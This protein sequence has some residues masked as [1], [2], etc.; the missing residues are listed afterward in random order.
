MVPFKPGVVSHACDPSTRKS[1]EGRPGVGSHPGLQG[2]LEKWWELYKLKELA[3]VD[4]IN[5]NRG[6]FVLLLLLVYLFLIR[7]NRIQD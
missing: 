5:G 1:E 2:S 4:Q 7:E 3:E 6:Y